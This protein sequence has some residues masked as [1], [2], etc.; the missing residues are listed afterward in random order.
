MD[1]NVNNSACCSGE[2]LV[3]YLYGEMPDVARVRFEDHLVA[4]TVCTDEFAE[5]S[6]GRF[7]VYE[8]N[9]IEFANIPTPVFAVPTVERAG[10]FERLAGLISI[11]P[12]WA[13]LAVAAAAVVATLGGVM[14]FRTGT[15]VRD[16]TAVDT[17]VVA[18]A[19]KPIAVPEKPVVPQ[20]EISTAASDDDT[21]AEPSGSKKAVVHVSGQRQ[22]RSRRSDRG[23][24]ASRRYEPRSAPRLTNVEVDEEASLRLADLLAEVEA[25]E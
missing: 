16:V 23:E 5:V 10:W 12:S 6:D 11:G 7:S 21:A 1:R 24:T 18:E 15:E 25:N 22:A 19:Q 4:C 3:S 9:K 14:L 17:P 20:D 2:D 13:K 8:W